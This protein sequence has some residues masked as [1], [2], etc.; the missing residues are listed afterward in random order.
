MYDLGFDFLINGVCVL[1]STRFS[2]QR[3][4]RYKHGDY[5]F[6]LSSRNIDIGGKSW[7]LML[8]KIFIVAV[9][10]PLVF[11]S[12]IGQWMD[13]P[14]LEACIISLCDEASSCGFP[15]WTISEPSYGSCKKRCSG[16]P[17]IILS[18]M[19]QILSKSES[20]NSPMCCPNKSNLLKSKK[21]GLVLQTLL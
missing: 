16:R 13:T 2:H 3:A 5:C 6:K 21:K 12:F 1:I 8:P 10:S 18:S 20:D 7:N 19:T 17:S 4:P 15:P 9:R 11:H 14:S